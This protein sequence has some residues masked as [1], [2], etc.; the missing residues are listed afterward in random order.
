[1]TTAIVA[2]YWVQPV[3]SPLKYIERRRNALL[4]VENIDFRWR[5]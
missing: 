1:V 5:T 2:T 3:H 4:F